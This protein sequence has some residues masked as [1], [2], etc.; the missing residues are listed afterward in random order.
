MAEQEQ[1]IVDDQIESDEEKK[2][3]EEKEER[4]RRLQEIISSNPQQQEEG[5]LESSGNTELGA[6]TVLAPEDTIQGFED[7]KENT[8]TQ[9]PEVPLEETTPLDQNKNVE[10]PIEEPFKFEDDKQIK[11]EKKL[12]EN[13]VNFEAG[14]KFYEALNNDEDIDLE[15]MSYE[16][17]EQEHLGSEEGLKSIWDWYYEDMTWS[18]EKE[19]KAFKNWESSIR[20]IDPETGGSVEGGEETPKFHDLKTELLWLDLSE[21]EREA[22]N[23]ADNETRLKV[24]ER[25]LERARK[26]KEQETTEQEKEE[27]RLK[28]ESKFNPEEG[29][30][31]VQTFETESVLSQDIQA[32]KEKAETQLDNVFQ[33][34]R[35]VTE[36]QK[37]IAIEKKMIEKADVVVSQAK[38]EG[39]SLD[40]YIDSHKLSSLNLMSDEEKALGLRI[41]V[42]ID[43]RIKEL[44]NDKELIVRNKGEEFFNQQL[45]GLEEEKRDAIQS[46]LEPINEKIRDLK[47][48]LP[49]LKDVEEREAIEKSITDLENQK[50]LLVMDN[51]EESF[52]AV[53]NSFNENTTQIMK[54]I[55]SMV[56]LENPEATSKQKFDLWFTAY[57]ETTIEQLRELDWIEEEGKDANGRE[58]LKIDLP[59]IGLQGR[60]LLGADSILGI[61][62][63]EGKL[64]LTRKEKEALANIGALNAMIPVYA[65]NRVSADT[66]G[67]MD[68]FISSMVGFFTPNVERARTTLQQTR[69]AQANEYINKWGIEVDEKTLSGI[70]EGS[71]PGEIGS[72]VENG[73]LLGMVTALVSELVVTRGIG[74]GV[75][76]VAKGTKGAATAGRFGARMERTA[77]AF[78][79]AVKA[80]KLKVKSKLLKSDKIT[81]LQNFMK[82]TTRG[83]VISNAALEGARFEIAG[84][85]FQTNEEEFNFWSGFG[86][87]MIGGVLEAG[88]GKFSQSMYHNLINR[89][90]VDGTKRVLTNVKNIT[91]WATQ[92]GSRGVGETGEEV[93]QEI[94]Q[95][96]RRTEG[97]KDFFDVVTETVGKLA[98][99][100]KFL[101]ETFAM[102]LAFGGAFKPFTSTYK[103]YKQKH[104]RDLAFEKWASGLTNEAAATFTE[105]ADESAVQERGEKGLRTPSETISDFDETL[106]NK[107][108]TDEELEA[109]IEE[110]ES[111]GKENA[112]TE[113]KVKDTVGNEKIARLA[114]LKRT[115]KDLLSGELTDA[116]VEQ[117]SEV[118]LEIEQI[119]REKHDARKSE[120]DTSVKTTMSEIDPKSKIK[121]GD[122]LS[123][124]NVEGVS[125]NSKVT[126]ALANGSFETLRNGSK[127]IF[128]RRQIE[129]L[130]ENGTLEMFRETEIKKEEK[131]KPEE[132]EVKDSKEEE[133][134]SLNE[135]EIT[136]EILELTEKE[137]LTE[138]QEVKLKELNSSL[139][140]IQESETKEV[141]SEEKKTVSESKKDRISEID[142]E[143]EKIKK[144]KGS[145]T[146]KRRKA[147]ELND[148]K[149][150]LK[151]EI[152]QTGKVK[153]T[154]EK[155]YKGFNSEGQAVTVENVSKGKWVLTDESGNTSE[156]TS[157]TKA[158]AAIA[159]EA[160]AKSEEV[161]EEKKEKPK[162]KA[163]K[164]KSRKLSPKQ[165]KVV[166]AKR[167]TE[168][169]LTKVQKDAE[170]KAKKEFE[171]KKDPK[172]LANEKKIQILA[173]KID[174]VKAEGLAAFKEGVNPKITLEKQAALQEEMDKL[175]A[176]TKAIKA[177]Q[178]SEFQLAI[179][180]IKGGTKMMK[181]GAKDIIDGLKN[182][183]GEAFAVIPGVSVPLSG[184]SMLKI[185]KGVIRMVYGA[186]S[187]GV[188]I[189][190]DSPIA[191]VSETIFQ[192]LKGLDVA[193]GAIINWTKEL[194]RW[195]LKG[196]D[197]KI[198]AGKIAEKMK[199]KEFDNSAIDLNTS[200]PSIAR[201][202]EDVVSDVVNIM[203]A[204]PNMTVEQVSV[205]LR[206]QAASYMALQTSQTD[207]TRNEFG[208]IA[209]SL[210]KLSR[211]T[212]G[213]T[214]IEDVN[215]ALAEEID[216]T[217]QR[218][219]DVLFTNR[220]KLALSHEARRGIKGKVLDLIYGRRGDIYGKKVHDDIKIRDLKKDLNNKWERM[221]LTIL[222]QGGGDIPSKFTKISQK[223]RERINELV[224]NPTKEMNAW[225]NILE[226]RYKEMFDGMETAD[227][228]TSDSYI[229]NYVPQFWDLNHKSATKEN[230]DKFKRESKLSRNSK[231]SKKRYH[232]TY[233]DGIRNN[234]VP[235]TLDAG[236]IFS[237]YSKS[238][239]TV[240][241][242]RNFVEGIWDL[243]TDT[244]VPLVTLTD[245]E[246][247][248]EI[249]GYVVIDNR[250]LAKPTWQGKDKD[251]NNRWGAS[252]IAVHPDIARYVKAI[253]DNGFQ[254]KGA[255]A[256]LGIQQ[257]IKKQQLSL[258]VF[259]HWALSETMFA[260]PKGI[261][262][263]FAVFNPYEV[264]RKI[265]NGE[266]VN[267][268]FKDL[269]ATKFALESALGIDVAPDI[270]RELVDSMMDK[271]SSWM[272]KALLRTKES[273]GGEASVVWKDKNGKLK[274][275]TMNPLK[276]GSNVFKTW[277]KFLWDYL[278]NTYKLTGFNT[279][280]ANWDARNPNATV[281]QRKAQGRAAAQTVND[282]F[283]GQVWEVL[284]V[285]KTQ[286]QMAQMMFL[287]PDWTLSTARQF[288][289][290]FAGFSDS[291][292]FR[293]VT[294]DGTSRTSPGKQ[295]MREVIGEKF[296]NLDTAKNLD[297]KD[298]MRRMG[299]KFWVGFV[300]KNMLM[301]SAMNYYTT[302]HW[303]DED[304][305]GD[306]KMMW[307]NDK[308][309]MTGLY[310]GRGKAT[311]QKM[312]ISMFKQARE[313][314]DWV[315]SP[316]AFVQRLASKSAPGLKLVIG[317]LS[318]ATAFDPK[319]TS[320]DAA[321]DAVM[322]F[323]LSTFMKKH[324]DLTA[325]DKVFQA[326]FR[327]KKGYTNDK[328]KYELVDA[329]VNGEDDATIYDIIEDGNNSDLNT[330]LI[331]N[332]ARQIANKIFLQ[333]IKEEREIYGSEVTGLPSKVRLIRNESN[334]KE[335]IEK[336]K[337]LTKRVQTL[338]SRT[339]NIRA[340]R[341]K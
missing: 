188:G 73:K 15:G 245:A 72:A 191:A 288:M 108:F 105:A 14:M 141:V 59:I 227:V 35:I 5:I 115:K 299:L 77:I 283:G 12:L 143:L 339:K 221:A 26:E 32:T 50:R 244:G 148:E 319:R 285:S 110:D 119:I 156:F 313:M 89:F 160:E 140:K 264:W 325:T 47:G 187:V 329:L 151:S 113:A 33:I 334:R 193:G 3:R 251:G 128:N 246:G 51:P 116:D 286:Q 98:G 112:A 100:K 307:E 189:G 279:W 7:P 268:V 123:I 295:S 249:D 92:T 75:G 150:L 174:K 38:N 219:I 28:K 146:F 153:K 236:D 195:V 315:E 70:E 27:E 82:N 54:K 266:E 129:T 111:F 327:F 172:I 17:F 208:M 22:Y 132:A 134:Q 37:D 39:I 149:T 205:Y 206:Q 302:K 294:G 154:G 276:A 61:P 253:T 194:V 280:M 4:E 76:L 265:Q 162:P 69:L 223:D 117:L 332:Q 234:L 297:N 203:K 121:V 175:I 107:E 179:R 36:L 316:E 305:E 183:G 145:A 184:D 335:W 240:L 178:V 40:D 57:K 93:M 126:K 293:A 80:G 198:F 331:L 102:G 25:S 260:T 337:Q 46:Q 49:G 224:K 142:K 109:V 213:M 200:A 23:V 55:Y 1:E 320:T 267:A 230:I 74:K 341:R 81:Q 254:S 330:A 95:E 263:S 257:F 199:G 21:K 232:Q 133:D 106:K 71:K 85:I 94:I 165:E 252:K 262:N 214:Q 101:Y 272:D 250:A 306:G 11:P 42:G 323:A 137:E 176:E 256:V 130:I 88:I 318:P 202:W 207:K 218:H 284:G 290:M 274:S 136:A 291:K 91:K 29:I 190:L 157:L 31:D 215:K 56:E 87:K 60:D 169:K 166:L 158:K 170:A 147:K 235:M 18:K 122:V 90:G 144:E 238:Y 300:T 131:A 310:W 242:N 41:E 326:A 83:K 220:E 9:E 324:E 68:G 216:P 84:E 124:K 53:K 168:A 287:S 233:L 239:H 6:D 67:F 103:T 152:S 281:E 322:M 212:E 181:K 63:P 159:K 204:T 167:K 209:S 309:N 311:G 52:D 261:Q 86:G 135:E 164:T 155:E 30:A 58:I 271:A 201:E 161:K 99:D 104:G 138:E 78:D 180:N 336:M 125:E 66:D 24:A 255:K 226:S 328:M 258:S 304:D 186:G 177:K 317:T 211:D 48:D 97:H 248:A 296:S 163:K 289:N 34:E 139:E 314:F 340:K 173:D 2:E 62:I 43:A 277:D 333:D 298:E 19:E 8:T 275:I 259:H 65:T 16:E 229:E 79:R 292:T 217:S 273:K 13:N 321:I 210:M 247:N 127:V 197:N 118:N 196:I 228:V 243:Q 241:A 114:E 185:G 237:M 231:H 171:E 282:T 64:N 312:Y 182:E 308:D 45:E 225:K 96:W 301:M 192:T 303:G 338:K 20:L 120:V 269:D 44:N 270:S 10:T 278:H 222:M